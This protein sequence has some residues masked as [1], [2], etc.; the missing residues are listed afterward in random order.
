M[1]KESGARSTK[2]D[3]SAAPSNTTATRVIHKS[4]VWLFLRCG[5]ADDGT[6]LAKAG[7]HG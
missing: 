7:R 1:G 2:P 6:W 5:P 4:M 3:I